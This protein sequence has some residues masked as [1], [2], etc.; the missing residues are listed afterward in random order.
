MVCIQ[1][2]QKRN[3]RRDKGTQSE[4]H[5]NHLNILYVRKEGEEADTGGNDLEF[6]FE[7]RL[8]CES[9]RQYDTPGIDTILY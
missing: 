7:A 8:D 9:N 6:S 2:K 4:D 3:S 5:A 1:E